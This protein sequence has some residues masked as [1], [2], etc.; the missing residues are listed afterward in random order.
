MPN[1]KSLR[2]Q[3]RAQRQSLD[4]TTQIMAATQL[5][6]QVS[7]LPIFKAS[8]HI[9]GYIA[10]DNEANPAAILAIG[11]QQNKKCYLPVL[12]TNKQLDFIAYQPGD[13]LHK[14]R[15]QIP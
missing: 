1:R 15:Y 7:K 14:N 13:S 2:Q 9:A 12:N 5:A 8:Q 11:R 3:L 10:N 6:A 4:Q